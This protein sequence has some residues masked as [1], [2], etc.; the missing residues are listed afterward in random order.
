MKSAR[1][2]LAQKQELNNA[3]LNEFISW[4]I[5]GLKK[6]IRLDSNQELLLNNLIDEQIKKDTSLLTVITIA[7]WINSCDL[8]V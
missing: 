7:T 5:T 4:I 1:C 6:G 3:K 2:I 8:L